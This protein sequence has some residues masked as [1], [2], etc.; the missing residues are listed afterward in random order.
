M[1]GIAKGETNPNAKLTGA[2]VIEIKKM[3]KSGASDGAI[4]AQ[5]ALSHNQYHKIKHGRT[6]THIVV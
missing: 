6:W 5:F 3:I 4:K 2:Q 1:Y